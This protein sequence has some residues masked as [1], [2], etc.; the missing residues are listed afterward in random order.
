MGATIPALRR[1]L[2]LIR[3]SPVLIAGGLIALAG[4]FFTTVLLSFVLIGQLIPGAAFAALGAGV[5]GMV[6]VAAR[7]GQEPSLSV[8]RETLTEDGLTVFG[9]YALKALVQFVAMT[10]GTLLGMLVG[11]VVV[12]VLGVGSLALADTANDPSA[13]EWALTGPAVLGLLSIAAAAVVPVFLVYAALQFVN[14]AIV[15]GDHDV[16]EAFAESWKLFRESPAS[17]VGYTLVRASLFLVAIGVVIGSWQVASAVSGSLGVGV[18]V[19]SLFVVGILVWTVNHVYHA[20]YYIH[21]RPESVRV[22][23]P[24]RGEGHGQDRE[25][26]RQTR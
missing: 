12:T 18:A 4:G 1:S 5:L 22:D 17:V 21:R 6:H 2:E 11:L 25:R 23:Q 24:T 13:W 20:Q 14:V 7:E 10:V 9:G 26:R 3:R 15:V 8:Y 16:T 19:L